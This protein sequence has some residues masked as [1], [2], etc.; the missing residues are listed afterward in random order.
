MSSLEDRMAAELVECCLELHRQRLLA[1]ADGNVS[2]RLDDERILITPAGVAK[3]L[4]KLTDLAV[5]RLDGSV[6]DGKPSSEKQLH[7]EVYRRSPLARAVLHAHPPTAVAWSVAHPEYTELPGE[8]LSEL[9]LAAGS[10]PLVPYARPASLEAAAAV[11][12]Y[13]PAHRALILARH[14]ALT[15]G[16]SLTEVLNGMERIEHSAQIL[17]AAF[18][19]GGLTKLPPDEIA[20][21]RALRAALGERLL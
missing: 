11:R 20:G 14:G 8:C 10:I 7:L 21:L 1:G 4:L 16:E 5:I 3:R 12:P 9:I 15:W 6:I 19:L 18:E 2:F 13:L 17:K